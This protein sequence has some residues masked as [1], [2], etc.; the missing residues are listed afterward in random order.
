MLDEIQKNIIDNDITQYE[1]HNSQDGL[2]TEYTY[3]LKTVYEMP[4]E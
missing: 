3:K 1:Y 2:K 4:K